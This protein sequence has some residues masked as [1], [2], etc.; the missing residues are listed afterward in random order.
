MSMGVL[1]AAAA[2]NVMVGAL[3]ASGL[4]PPRKVH[5]LNVG[6]EP[7]AISCLGGFEENLPE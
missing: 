4:W 3:D 1:G 2:A 7:N 6:A 5:S